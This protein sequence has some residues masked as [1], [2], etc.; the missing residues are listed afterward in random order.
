MKKVNIIKKAE[1]H[2]LLHKILCCL[3]G[4][5]HTF[6]RLSYLVTKILVW[7]LQMVSSFPSVRPLRHARNFFWSRGKTSTNVKAFCLQYVSL[8]QSS[9]RETPTVHGLSSIFPEINFE[10]WL[11]GNLSMKLCV[12]YWLKTSVWRRGKGA[13][14]WV[15]SMSAGF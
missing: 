7:W 13:R 12:E 5:Q 3:K 8:W 15:K 2:L 10:M 14:D 1:I 9:L 4:S 11:T 6:C